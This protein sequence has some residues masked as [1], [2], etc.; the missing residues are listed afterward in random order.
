MHDRTGKELSVMNSSYELNHKISAEFYAQQIA[1]LNICIK[2]KS[3]WQ[4]GVSFQHNML[5]FHTTI[6]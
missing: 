1:K 4:Q 2:V 6:I 5:F 3:N